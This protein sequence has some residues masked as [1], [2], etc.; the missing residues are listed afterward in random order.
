MKWIADEYKKHFAVKNPTATS[1]HLGVA[2]SLSPETAS[3][4]LSS[5]F[6]RSS[7]LVCLVSRAHVGKWRLGSDPRV[8]GPLPPP[9]SWS[10]IRTLKKQWRKTRRHH[11]DVSRRRILPIVLREVGMALKGVMTRKKK[12]MPIQLT[13]IRPVYHQ[14]LTDY[15]KE[16]TGIQ[17]IQ[18]D[19]GVSLSEALLMHDK[20]L[21]DK[22]IKHKSFAVVTWGNWDCRTMLESECKFKRIRK[23]PYFNRWINLKGSF[24]DIFGVRCNL[25]EAVELSGL[26]WE[27]RPHCGLDDARNT[28]R[29]LALLMHWGFRFSITNELPL[30]PI[31]QPL[32]Y[33]P[34]NSHPIDP[35]QHLQKLKELPGPIPQFHPFMDPTGNETFTYCFCGVMSSKCVIRK[36]GPMQGRCFFGCG[37]WTPSRRAVCNYFVWASP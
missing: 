10:T 30:P 15:C 26:T 9:R 14:L 29:L 23:P 22:G 6:P 20:W 7:L 31:D 35:T 24:Q 19:R 4:L 1:N 27:G 37:N 8:G 18:V 34:F 5:P 25:K 11:L 32:T 13:Y 2:L 17:Q 3:F 16:L 28:A 36:P 33:R 12:S 21:E